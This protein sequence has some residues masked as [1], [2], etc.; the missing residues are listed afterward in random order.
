VRLEKRVAGRTYCS[1]GKK[2]V[3]S[4]EV[5]DV[6]KALEDSLAVLPQLFEK[7][8]SELSLFMGRKLEFSPEQAELEVLES[9][10]RNIVPI[11]ARL[12]ELGSEP[13]TPESAGEVY[14]LLSHLIRLSVL[15]V[16]E[17][18]EAVEYLVEQMAQMVKVPSGISILK[19]LDYSKN[20]W[21]CSNLSMKR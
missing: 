14:E 17:K 20:T 5:N 10:L 11:V 8:G 2:D 6:D 21:A 15:S 4:G 13:L 12:Q 19:E 3:S 7:L 18:K 1:P 9:T 16:P